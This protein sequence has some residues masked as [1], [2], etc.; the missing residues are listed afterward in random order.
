MNCSL[1]CCFRFS[2]NL[3]GRAVHA[4]GARDFRELWAD[5]IGAHSAW[6]VN[7]FIFAVITNQSCRTILSLTLSFAQESCGSLLVYSCFLG[8]ILK[9]LLMTT[10][11]NAVLVSSA[12][13]VPL[14]LLKD[15]SAL[16]PLAYTGIAAVVY[17]TVMRYMSLCVFYLY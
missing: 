2:F 4:T 1:L 15:L 14:V 8:D 13:L 7:F 10:R 6:V 17:T 11:T 3:V 9:S 16:A 12:L 5:T